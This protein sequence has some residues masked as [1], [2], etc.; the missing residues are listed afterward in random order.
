[1]ERVSA[2]KLLEFAGCDYCKALFEI[3]RLI[4]YHASPC[5]Y[6]KTFREIEEAALAIVRRVDVTRAVRSLASKLMD[7][8]TL[9][10]EA[11]HAL[12]EASGLPFNSITIRASARCERDPSNQ[13]KDN[14]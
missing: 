8:G 3:H 7:F 5:E 10:G 4:G 12:I 11:A 9:D 6:L 14:V 13:R 2:L 1:M